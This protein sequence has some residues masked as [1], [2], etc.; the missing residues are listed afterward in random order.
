MRNYQNFL[1]AAIC[2]VFS[3]LITL[4]LRTSGNHDLDNVS[5]PSPPSHVTL[6]IILAVTEN[7]AVVT[8]CSERLVITI[9]QFREQLYE[10]HSNH[11]I[12]VETDVHRGHECISEEVFEYRFLPLPMFLVSVPCH[13]SG[14]FNV[15]FWAYV[16]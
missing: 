4:V 2:S 6:G 5:W 15:S 16:G 7:Q 10:L 3:M 13:R 1:F 11:I 12:D 14:G 9:V 8:H